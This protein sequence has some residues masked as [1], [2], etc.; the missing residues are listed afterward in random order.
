MAIAYISGI[1]N[2]DDSGSR[3]TSIATAGLSVSGGNSIVVSVHAGDC[4][5]SVTGITDT[6]GNTYN[7]LGD[8]W[9]NDEGLTYTSKYSIWIAVN[10]TGN[11]SNV[12]TAAFASAVYPRICAMQL[13]GVDNSSPHDTGFN[14]AGVADD[15]TDPYT[16][17]S[18]NT[19]IAGEWIVGH[20]GAENGGPFT[21]SSP[22]VVRVNTAGSWS[23]SCLASNLISSAGSGSVSASGATGPVNCYSKAIKPSNPSMTISE[24]LSFAEALD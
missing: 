11:A 8:E 21:D 9:S 14:P 16:A 20:F 18:G 12:I 19:A 23:D 22:S 4:N 7:R 17:G 6:A 2:Q 3:F 13:S 24:T 5:G 10:I 15:S 1:A